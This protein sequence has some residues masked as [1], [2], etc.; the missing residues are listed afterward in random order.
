MKNYGKLGTPTFITVHW[1]AGT[2]TR[3]HEEYHFCITYNLATGRA[4]VVQTRPIALKGAHVRG[5][6]SHN[7][8]IALC[9]MGTDPKTGKRYEIQPAQIEACAKLIAELQQLYS[10]PEGDVVDHAH[11]AKLD[12][13]HPTSRPITTRDTRWDIGD[14]LEPIKAKARWYFGKLKAGAIARQYT[15]SLR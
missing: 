15:V 14:L 8:G 12:G 7:I 13:Y 4:S 6:N 9:G 1:T 11:W 2:F 10:L 5:R 3:T